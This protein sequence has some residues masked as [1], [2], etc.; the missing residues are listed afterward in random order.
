MDGRNVVLDNSLKEKET[1]QWLS[2]LL[3]RHVEIVPRVNYPKN[4]PTPD[5]LVDGVKFDLKK[6]SG[7]GKN[8]FDNA[9]KK[10]KE[11]AEN[12]V[13]DITN[14]PLSEAEIFGLLDKVYKSGRRGLNTALIK[15]SDKVIDIIKPKEK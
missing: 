3:G 14:T 1:A 11:Q 4:I 7:S 12:I 10:A 9:S 6:I 5:Y 8:V 15:K 13:F 2:E